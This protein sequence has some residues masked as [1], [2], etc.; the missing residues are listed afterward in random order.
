MNLKFPYRA[1]SSVESDFYPSNKDDDGK[2]DDYNFV[3][4][5]I[6]RFREGRVLDTIQRM[7]EKDGE[8]GEKVLDV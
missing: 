2:E 8:Q 5:V 1:T 3:G 7:K 4:D 6:Y